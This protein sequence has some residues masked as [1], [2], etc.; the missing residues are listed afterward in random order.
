MGKEL[1]HANSCAPVKRATTTTGEEKW[2]KDAEKYRRINGE[3]RGKESDD[4]GFRRM[5]WK[6]HED[7]REKGG[8]NANLGEWIRYML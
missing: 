1:K 4:G 7:R 5:N 6:R 8:K 3:Q 2:L